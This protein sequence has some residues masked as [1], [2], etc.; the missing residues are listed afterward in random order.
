[1]EISRKKIEESVEREFK[2]AREWCEGDFGRCYAM[3]IDLEDGEIWSDVF[4]DEW[5][6]KIYHSSYV[7]HLSYGGIPFATASEKEQGYIDDAIQQLQ[8][9]GWTIVE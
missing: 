3:M 2:S 6:R 5:T 8:E 7:Q 4:L 1:M 9:A